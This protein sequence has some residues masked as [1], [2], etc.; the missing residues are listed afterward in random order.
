M[1]FENKKMEDV[2]EHQE[3]D[4]LTDEKKSS[5]FTLEDYI[6]ALEGFG[7][8][9]GFDLKHLPEDVDDVH[10]YRREDGGYIVNGGW[11]E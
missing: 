10:F 1:D 11:V 4:D 3:M 5:Q 6:K 2:S 8:V 7:V 9:I